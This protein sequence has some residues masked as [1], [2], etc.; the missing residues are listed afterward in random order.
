MAIS[1]AHGNGS[2][3]YDPIPMKLSLSKRVT[4]SFRNLNGWAFKTADWAL[5]QAYDAALMI[6]A[7][8]DE[9]FQGQ[10]IDR[11][12][13]AHREVLQTCFQD[14]LTTNLQTIRTRLQEFQVSRS[15]TEPWSQG[16]LSLDLSQVWGKPYSQKIEDYNILLEKLQFIDQVLERYPAASAPTP[17]PQKPNLPTAKKQASQSLVPFQSGQPNTPNTVPELSR[18]PIPAPASQASRDVNGADNG[19]DN[20]EPESKGKA[21]QTRFLPRS[22]LGTIDR[23]RRELDPSAE[24]EVVRT[25]RVSKTKTVI[26]LKFILLLILIPL[27]IHQ[28]SK[29]FLVG[30]IIDQIRGEPHQVDVS[31]LNHLNQDLE[32]EVLMELQ[33]YQEKLQF[34]NFLAFP[35]VKYSPETLQELYQIE[36]I[37]LAQEYGFRSANAVKNVFADLCS[38]IAFGIVLIYRQ[39]DFAV[40]K[41]FVDE[42]I[43]GLSD[44]AKAFIIILF[45]DM[46]VGFHSPHGWEVILEGISR[47]FGIVESR[48]FIFLFIATFPV[49]LDTIFKYWIFR[50]L[51]RISPSAVATYRNM[52]E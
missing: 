5:E 38:L 25:F 8:E 27:L 13:C 49:I 50:Y 9:H 16:L 22:I 19:A 45:T 23:L 31:F 33:R 12:N 41:S 35:Q 26:S 6:K 32:D 21:E 1:V 36:A 15:Q 47:H 29:N 39:A 48:S 2:H 51:N 44:S 30:P 34:E 4:R 10:T 24:Q 37:E 28:I 20:R 46:F 3:S 14:E 52:N 40:F 18:L 11:Q 7:I 43:Y 42:L 17:N